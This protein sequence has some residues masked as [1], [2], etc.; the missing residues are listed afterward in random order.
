MPS[1]PNSPSVAG[2]CRR[3]LLASGVLVAVL[4]S[5][6][7]T[8][9]AAP[10]TRAAGPEAPYLVSVVDG[11]AG[12]LAAELRAA[13][14]AVTRELD[15]VGV[16]GVRTSGDVAARLAAD[17][18][19]L[20]TRADQ[21]VALQASRWS[22]A[23]DAGSLLNVTADVEARKQ[24]SVSTGRGVDVA[25]LDSGVTPVPGLDGAGKLVQGPDLSF[26][27]GDPAL[28][29]LDTFG[30]GTHMAGIIAGRDAGFSGADDTTHF[31]GVAPDA[32]VVSVKVADAY[33]NADVSQII[34]G[35]DWVVQHRHDAGM[36]I[37]VLNLSLG[38][39]SG[40]AYRV[41]PL[42][43]AA[44]QA[45]LAGIVVVAS[46]GNDGSSTG[47]L[48]SPAYDPYVLAVGAVDSKGTVS[49]VD[50][51]VSDFSNVGAVHRTPDLVA[52]GRSITSL[53]VPGSYLD[54]QYPGAVTAGRFFRGTG[55]S[56]SAAI[57]SGAVA[58]LLQHRPHLAPDQTRSVL[59]SSA[60]K[61]PQVSAVSQGQGLVRVAAADRRRPG[62]TLLHPVRS[63]GT[64]ALDAARG[65]Y[66]V[67]SDG[68]A[69]TGERDVFGR[70]FSAP[71]HAAAAADGRAWTGGA[72]N[73]SVY[74]GTAFGPDGAWSAA[75]WTG[76][77]WAGRPWT[78]AGTT[79]AS[80]DGRTWAGGYW[81]GR[82]WA[83]RTWAGRT[84][85]TGSWS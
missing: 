20:G 21:G 31:A 44:E 64:G 68:V 45:W 36:D 7:A 49:P 1:T 47:A 42:A 48:L 70:T 80:W 11:Q 24:W 46:A 81:S 82:T 54:Q 50:D 71:A 16:L 5:G 28:R 61:L 56:Q 65:G 77:D 72:W 75:T 3:A 30:H 69:L 17:P 67:E 53:R 6:A 40:N 23:D 55:T 58:L 13:G 29:G 32:R 41:D 62:L 34:A 84:W 78:V 35:I 37:R 22:A 66:R 73:G 83:G 57:V 4:A 63:V 8:A 85:A 52:P 76:T 19:V 10:A 12:P 18:R 15:A 59:M 9:T 26:D 25:L 79:G 74:T 51:V 27:T 33:G 38:L 60:K 43:H 39:P 14:V 2:G